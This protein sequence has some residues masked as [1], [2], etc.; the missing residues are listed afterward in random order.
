MR[1]CS[2]IAVLTKL[3]AFEAVIAERSCSMMRS[4]VRSTGPAALPSALAMTGKGVT[5]GVLVSPSTLQFGFVPCGA[6]Q[7]A[8]QVTLKN[9][10]G[11]DF[12]W[13]AALNK[14]GTSAYSVDKTNGT[15]KAGDTLTLTLKPNKIPSN[16]STQADF[17]G[18]VLTVTTTAQGNETI[19]IPLHMTAYGAILSLAP[20]SIDFGL[21]KSDK[22]SK[23]STFSVVNSGNAPANVSI[24]SLSSQFSVSLGSSQVAGNGGAAQGSATF[25]PTDSGQHKGSVQ[26]STQTGLCA[27]LPSG[28]DYLKGVGF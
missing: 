4:A 3:T 5:G 24:K 15:V 11:A 26:L 23:S 1:A 16:S 13:S 28:V 22:N 6:Q 27:P 14:G 2:A 21:V 7:A 9:G 10:T 17:Y 12:T 18:D 25:A 20:N 19:A 8:K